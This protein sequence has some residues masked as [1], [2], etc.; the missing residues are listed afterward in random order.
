MSAK[1]FSLT[2]RKGRMEMGALLSEINGM[3]GR[4]NTAIVVVR[5]ADRTE[6]AAATATGDGMET[7]RLDTLLTQGGEPIFVIGI[8]VDSASREVTSSVLPLQ[9]AAIASLP[10]SGTRKVGKKKSIAK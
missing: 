10:K 7:G 2:N 1:T 9:E 4:F 5:L 6:F 3:L 8:T